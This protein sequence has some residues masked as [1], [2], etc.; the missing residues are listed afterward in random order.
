MSAVFILYRILC[1]QKG[2]QNTYY[3]DNITRASTLPASNIKEYSNGEC[4][5]DSDKASTL[6][7]RILPA[8]KIGNYERRQRHVSSPS[9]LN[10]ATQN[11]FSAPNTPRMRTSSASSNVSRRYSACKRATPTHI[12][13]HLDKKLVRSRSVGVLSNFELKMHRTA[14]AS[15]VKM[16]ECEEWII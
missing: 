11:G 5:T 10:Y 13:E 15:V 12:P 14:S 6:Q 9:H 2:D 3:N 4:P 16:D 8:Y 1:L 7:A